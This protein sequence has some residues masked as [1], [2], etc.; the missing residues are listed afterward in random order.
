MELPEHG[1][2]RGSWD[3]R[4]GV[5]EYL[6]GVEFRRKRALD[7]G[8]AS[9][10]VCFEMERRGAEV[11]AFDL[12]HKHDWDLVP[13]ARHDHPRGAAERQAHIDMLNNS[14]WLS[15]RAHASA[16]RVVHGS[17]YEIPLAIGPVDVASLGCILLHLRDPFLALSR[18]LRLV[19]ETVIV[20]EFLGETAEQRS[21]FW[22]RIGRR[23][24]IRGQ[25]VAKDEPRMAFLP[26]AE[27]CM[28][29]ETWWRLNPEI[30]C[31]FLQVLGF[32]DVRVNFH[33]QEFDGRL[34]RL[35]TV[36]GRRTDGSAIP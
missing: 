7:V 30:V 10:F 29:K 32:R 11:V 4:K 18:V 27:T 9:G 36:V 8:T 24:G 5:N 25:S 22:R 28:P 12:S 26:D 6:G 1:I 33:T 20:V 15:H 2:V 16:A 19:R 17:V 31:R 21:G 35:F 3:L 23:L 14:F 34:A 13:Y